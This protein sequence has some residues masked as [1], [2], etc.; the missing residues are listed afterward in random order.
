LHTAS[1]LSGGEKEKENSISSSV[2]R[3]C[4]LVD[5]AKKT[6]TAIDF[7]TFIFKLEESSDLPALFRFMFFCNKKQICDI[8]PL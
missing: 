6:V 8:K 7:Q 1:S 3:F 2:T 4:V 5:F